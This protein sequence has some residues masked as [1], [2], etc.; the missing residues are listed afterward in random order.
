MP[1]PA[2]KSKSSKLFT[3]TVFTIFTIKLSLGTLFYICRKSE[4]IPNP[5]IRTSKEKFA[6]AAAR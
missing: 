4:R 5:K 6:A 1:Q 3:A 2:A